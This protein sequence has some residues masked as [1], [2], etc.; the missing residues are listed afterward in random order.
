MFKAGDLVVV[1]IPGEKYGEFR[2]FFGIVIKSFEDSC[3]S[4]DPGKTRIMRKYIVMGR[5]G[6]ISNYFENYLSKIKDHV[7]NN[8]KELEDF[9]YNKKTG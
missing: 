3:Y 9:Y 1:N 2:T 6:K 5:S 4:I 8:H 7:L